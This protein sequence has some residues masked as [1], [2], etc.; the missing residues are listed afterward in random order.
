MTKKSKILIIALAVIILFSGLLLYKHQSNNQ[1]IDYKSDFHS[2]VNDTFLALCNT[3][4]YEYLNKHFIDSAS[5]ITF[6]ANLENFSIAPNYEGLSL[7]T[8]TRKNNNNSHLSTDI[9]AS[10]RGVQLLSGK[11]EYE[12]SNF[13]FYSP[14]IY[15]KVIAGDYNLIKDN[16]KIVYSGNIVYKLIEEFMNMYPDEIDTISQNICV[17]YDDGYDFTVKSTA[18][19]KFLNLLKIY[20]FDGDTCQDI[21]SNYLTSEYYANPNNSDYYT[22]EE[23]KEQYI[24]GNKSAIQSVFDFMADVINF[25]VTIHFDTDPDGNITSITYDDGNSDISG[26]IDLTLTPYGN[27]YNMEG[28]LSLKIAENIF[29]INLLQENSKE[30]MLLTTVNN[31][32]LSV[33]NNESFSFSFNSLLNTKTNEQTMTFDI[34]SPKY[35]LTLHCEGTYRSLNGDIIP[36][37][38]EELNL[39]DISI[40]ELTSFAKEIQENLSKIKERFN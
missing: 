36:I 32:T 31:S 28:Y 1:P 7:I 8:N 17:T 11:F 39:A 19:K 21:W 27:T 15:E 12:D 24:E 13:K 29:K 22:L 30:S 16:A 33:N 25:D 23:F 20:I 40:F 38:G 26:L 37:K 34:V 6:T 3:E 4:A 35:E 5:D 2:K 14:S 9:R 10:Y 18:V